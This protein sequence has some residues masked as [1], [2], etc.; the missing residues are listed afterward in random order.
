[1]KTILVVDGE[2][3]SRNLMEAVLSRAG[4]RA[5]IESHAQSAFA[6]VQRG[7]LPDLM[8][9]DY[10]LPDTDGLMLMHGI[11]KI[12]PALPVIMVTAHSG[13]ETYLKAMNMGVFEYLNKPVKARDLE[14]IVRAALLSPAPV[15]TRTTI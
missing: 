5:L 13:I 9:T 12:V 6:L 4:Y 7:L 1:M 10:C 8:I 11:R 2:A 14:C 3:T 15:S